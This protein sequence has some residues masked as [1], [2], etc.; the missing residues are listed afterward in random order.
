MTGY[1][2]P[3]VAVQMAGEPNLLSKGG[4]MTYQEPKIVRTE[5]IVVRSTTKDAKGYLIV[6][7]EGG[8]EHKISP[9]RESLFSL[10]AAGKAIHLSYAKY[11]SVEY[12]ANAT[13][14]EQMIK[15][16]KPAES[17]GVNVKIPE[18]GKIIPEKG[19]YKADP[20]KTESIERQTSLKSAIDLCVA[21]KIE[22]DQVISF[23]TVFDKYL[24]GDFVESESDILIKYVAKYGKKG[25]K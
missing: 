14:L 21:G 20:A 15:T 12:I 19:K 4:E 9:K 24:S 22:I 1:K 16:V 11:Q 13:P 6:T 2:D 10:F 18:I 5:D 23:A 3:E 8:K 7:D 17:G 25:V